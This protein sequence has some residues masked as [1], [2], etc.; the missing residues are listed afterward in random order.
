MGLLKLAALAAQLKSARSSA[1]GHAWR[2]Q[3]LA[4][5]S[6]LI[7]DAR[8]TQQLHLAGQVVEEET[9]ANDPLGAMLHEVEGLAPTA[10]VQCG[11]AI[12]SIESA[13]STKETHR[14]ALYSMRKSKKNGCF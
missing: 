10:A 8:V 1:A 13:A 5:R 11:G 12:E 9:L 7:G 2:R 3:T 4:L 14:N 6:L